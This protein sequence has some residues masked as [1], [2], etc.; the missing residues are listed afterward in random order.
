MKVV[1]MVSIA[2][3]YMEPGLNRTICALTGYQ[4]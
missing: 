4:S 1:A 2:L 3:D